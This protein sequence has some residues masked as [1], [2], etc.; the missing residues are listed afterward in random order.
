MTEEMAMIEEMAIRIRRMSLILIVEAESTDRRTTNQIIKI[1]TVEMMVEIMTVGIMITEIMIE[2]IT[3][4]TIEIVTA[5]IMIT[6]TTI[7]IIIMLTEGH[8]LLLLLNPSMRDPSTKV[9]S[10]DMNHAIDYSVSIFSCNDCGIC[11]Q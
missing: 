2:I 3:E 7:I 1:M 9:N 6:T 11:F 5:E 10:A 4:T 8:Q